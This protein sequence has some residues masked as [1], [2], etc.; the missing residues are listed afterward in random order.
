VAGRQGV[1]REINDCY[2]EIK[3]NWSWGMLP[4]NKRRVTS[5]QKLEQSM[6]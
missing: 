2:S 6:K 3:K 4:G 1:G 5:P